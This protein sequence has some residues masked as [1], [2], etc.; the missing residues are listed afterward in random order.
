M[1]GAESFRVTTSRCGDHH[2]FTSKEIEFEAGG[3]LQETYDVK[4]KMRKCA[5]T[6][7]VDVV[8]SVVVIGTQINAEELSRRHKKAFLNR[9]TIKSNIAYIMLQLAGFTKGK[10]ILDPF[11]GSGTILLEAAELAGNDM[12]GSGTDLVLKTV[13][14]VGKQK[15]GGG[16]NTILLISNRKC[17]GV[18]APLRWRR[19]VSGRVSTRVSSSECLVLR[20]LIPLPLLCT[21]STLPPDTH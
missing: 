17:W 8:A 2:S 10:A 15:R 4:P 6:V 12:K 19:V 18:S 20:S 16:E 5:V 13:K 1:I 3:A 21:F 11:C 14:S 7:R 9:V